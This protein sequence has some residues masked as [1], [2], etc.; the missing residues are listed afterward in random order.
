MSNMRVRTASR[1]TPAARAVAAGTQSAG[2]MRPPGK[3]HKPPMKDRVSARLVIRTCSAPESV[4]RSSRTV[5]AGA[6][7]ALVGTAVPL[8]AIVR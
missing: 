8:G 5:A 2:S 3:T 4:S 7:M 6:A 1:S